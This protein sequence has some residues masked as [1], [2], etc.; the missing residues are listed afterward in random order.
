MNRRRLEPG[1][2]GPIEP[3]GRVGRLYVVA[4][5][6]GNLA[7]LSPRA[8]QVLS[9]V[10]LVLAEDTRRI[11]KLLNYCGINTPA[12][13]FHE[14]NEAIETPR[15]LA[16]LRAG[17]VLALASDAGTPLLA[18]PG[19]RLVRASRHEGVPV[20][21][22][23]GP[24]AVAAALSV[25][26]LPPYPFTFAGFLPAA[27][28]ARGRTLATLAALPH[29]LV[30]FLSPHRLV[31]EL[32]DCAAALGGER[33]AALLAELTK[34]H[35]RCRTGSLAELATWAGSAVSRG[36]HTLVVGPPVQP[37]VP[38]T[39]AA[40]ARHALEAALAEGL[41]L[42]A[43]RRRAAQ[44]LGISRRALY[45]LLT[46]RPPETGRGPRRSARPGP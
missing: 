15:M 27:S 2:A 8:T 45:E 32:R 21:V 25:A 41:A 26:G 28:G 17:A 24:S 23:P 7:D 19:F 29:T 16:R 12:R 39:T 3:S 5:P 18:D 11:R 33:D 13:S 37:P 36:E 20:L 30:V 1:A 4:T 9:E 38:A 31:T 46:G 34:L 14:H 44:S 42:P 10:D 43:A 6:I 40:V 22:V 35:E